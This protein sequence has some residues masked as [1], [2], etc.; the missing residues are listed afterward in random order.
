MS[1]NDSPC[2]VYIP[3]HK[4]LEE[5]EGVLPRKERE[6]RTWHRTASEVVTYHEDDSKK[7]KKRGSQATST[8][9]KAQRPPQNSLVAIVLA[10]WRLGL[11]GGR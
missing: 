10:E 9:S 8:H 2:R 11:D 7:S 5:N 1:K 3:Y 6:V 4:T